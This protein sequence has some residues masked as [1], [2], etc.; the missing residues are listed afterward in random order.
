M[1]SKNRTYA[2]N[3]PKISAFEDV[4]TVE[5][6][7]VLGSRQWGGF[8]VNLHRHP[9]FEVDEFCL[10]EHVL[11]VHVAGRVRFWQKKGGR[12]GEGLSVP[13]E[14]SLS[15]AGLT[16]A[17]RLHSP[18]T[19]L[20]VRFEPRFFDRVASESF[21]VRGGRVELA[22]VPHAHD[23]RVE[24]IGAALTAEIRAGFP[25]GRLYGDSLATAL[26]AHILRAYTTQNSAPGEYKGGLAGHRL[27]QV[28]EYINEHLEQDL[29]L[30]EIAAAVGMNPYHLSRAFKQ[31]MGSAPHQYVIKRRVERAKVLLAETELTIIEVAFKVGFQSQS[32]FTNIFRRFTGVTP[33]AF[34]RLL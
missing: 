22:P 20:N 27:R 11:S 3:R 25:S 29:T 24:H 13:G 6:C 30:S 1:L 15:P 4:L 2:G 28:V 16:Q 34:R 10:D 31:E 7:S 32:H 5:D 26:T 14:M 17:M 9:P 33:K 23:P 21:E 12:E 19:V 8:A 18:V